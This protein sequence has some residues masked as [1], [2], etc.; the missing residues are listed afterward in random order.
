MADDRPRICVLGSLNVDLVVRSPRLPAPGETILGGPF[1]THAGGKGANQAVAASR[2]GAAVTMIGCVGVDE[3]GHHMR[4]ILAADGIDASRVVVRERTSTGLALITIADSGENTIVVVPGANAALTPADL[5]GHRDPIAQ[6]DVLLM[7]LETPPET[8]AAAAAIARDV[9]TTVML[10]A[11]PAIRLSAELLGAIDVL[12]VN[13]TEGAIVT[14]LAGG[15][16]G[17]GGVDGLAARLAELPVGTLV[18]TLGE[19]GSWHSHARGPGSRLDAYRVEP[20][21]TVGA[22]DAFVG[23]LATRWAELQIS[24]GR[25]GIDG[26]GVLD[27]ICWANAAGALACTRRGAIPSLPTR[28]EVRELLRR[29]ARDAAA[30]T[31]DAGSPRP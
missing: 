1:E 14:G 12:I 25:A 28:A 16:G 17:V 19:G 18:L 15:G 5:H 27:A 9:G 7:Q 8:V 10:N 22:G 4:S 2:M 21:D 13:E 11:A 29:E 20:I 26:M 31:G 23:A 30:R 24:A 6:A 3:H